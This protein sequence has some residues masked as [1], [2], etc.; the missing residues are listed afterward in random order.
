MTERGSGM[1][2][3]RYAKE[4]LGLL[5]AIQDSRAREAV[6]REIAQTNRDLARKEQEVQYE[7]WL[8]VDRLDEAAGSPSRR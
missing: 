7:L 4:R 2:P 1:K 8:S 3:K 5:E 6:H